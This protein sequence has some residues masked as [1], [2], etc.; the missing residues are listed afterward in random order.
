LHL[1]PENF[2]QHLKYE[3]QREDVNKWYKHVKYFDQLKAAHKTDNKFHNNNTGIKGT[4]LRLCN[5]LKKKFLKKKLYFLLPTYLVYQNL[6]SIDLATQ[7]KTRM[8][9]LNR[10]KFYQHFLQI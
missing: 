3:T 8:Y 1:E 5:T 2:Y 10:E 4:P 7:F 6:S 9:L